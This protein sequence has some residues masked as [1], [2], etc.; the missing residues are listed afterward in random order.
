MMQKEYNSFSGVTTLKQCKQ[1]LTN[2]FGSFVF[3]TG[4]M[5]RLFW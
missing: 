3:F 5:S 4:N 2:N 1:V